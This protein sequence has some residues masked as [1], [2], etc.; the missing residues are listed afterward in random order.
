MDKRLGLMCG[1][2]LP[3]PE[4]QI[5]I[6]QPRIKEIAL[7]GEQGFFTGVQTICINKKMFIQ[8]KTLLAETNNFQI[9]MTIMAEKETAEKRVAV[10][11]VMQ[12]LF[13][14][15]KVSFTPQ[16]ILFSRDGKITT[17]DSNNFEFLQNAIS[18]ICCLHSSSNDQQNYNPANDKAAEIAKKLMRGRQIAAE[19]KGENKS[20]VLSQY[21]STLTIGLNS[22]SLQDLMDLTLFQIYDL[23]ERYRL[24]IGWDLDIK[25]RLAGAKPESQPENWM[26]NIH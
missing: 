4:C 6:H 20:S 13:P 11:D 21:L 9:F 12:I 8:D 10:Q 25:Q 26:K 17:I 18:E 5:I 2:D 15:Y 19:Q 22:M 16:S 23:L 3:I 24:Y 7:V 1:I 14:T